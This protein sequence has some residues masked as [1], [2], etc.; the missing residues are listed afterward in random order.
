MV[1]ATDARVVT[2]AAGAQS[3]AAEVAVGSALL[4]SAAAVA[5]LRGHG[6]LCDHLAELSYTSRLLRFLARR[7]P[8]AAAAATSGTQQQLQAA[9]MPP[10]E[11]GSSAL[12]L[13]HQLASSVGASEALA[14]PQQRALVPSN[15]DG[16]NGVRARRERPGAAG[17]SEAHACARKPAARHA[18]CTSAAGAA[19]GVAAAAGKTCVYCTRSSVCTEQQPVAALKGSTFD[20]LPINYAP[21]TLISYIH[22]VMHVQLVLHQL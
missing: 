19:S 1:G 11:L 3:N 14:T 18:G 12:R 21:H 16:S 4:L 7:A 8:W 9:T 6:M 10:D 15:P 2:D 20:A 22:Q 17:D 5:L 13:L